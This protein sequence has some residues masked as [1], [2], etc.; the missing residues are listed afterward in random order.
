MSLIIREIQ[1]KMTMKCY[2]T[3]VRMAIINKSITN[4]CWRTCGE[5]GTLVHCWWQCRL[6]QPLWK[7]VWSYLNKIKMELPYDHATALLEY[8]PQKPETLI[9]NNICTPMFIVLFAIVKNWM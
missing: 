3:S 8:Y 1:I 9:G 4:K 5:K 2:L 7:A 6:V